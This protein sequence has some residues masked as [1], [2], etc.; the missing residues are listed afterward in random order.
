MNLLR[1]SNL[2]RVGG[3]LSGA[4]A[5]ILLLLGHLLDIGGDPQD[6]TVLGGTLVL[7]AHVALVFGLV[8]LWA[9]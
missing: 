1:Q 3:G 5:G 2:V 7:A 6:G 8:A 9:A 4:A